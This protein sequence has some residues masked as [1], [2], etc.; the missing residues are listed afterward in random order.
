MH[1]HA[2]TFIALHA[3]TCTHAH[4]HT[5]INT[6]LHGCL[7]TSRTCARPSSSCHTH[8]HISCTHAHPHTCQTILIAIYKISSTHLQAAGVSCYEHGSCQALEVRPGA[9]RDEGADIYGCL[10]SCMQECM[11]EHVLT[12]MR[13]RMGICGGMHACMC[14]SLHACAYLCMHVPLCAGLSGPDT[15]ECLVGGEKAPE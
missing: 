10:C 15:E 9:L 6:C 1:M 8:L 4:V 12:S 2:P 7:H 5:G 3:Q 13:M 11:H 14:L